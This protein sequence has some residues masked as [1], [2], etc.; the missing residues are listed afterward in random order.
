MRRSVPAVPVD[1]I[2]VQ[3]E[4]EEFEKECVDEVDEEQPHED[5][6]IQLFE[7]EQQGS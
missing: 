2:V 7:G 3:K 1:C 4:H 6:L 5:P